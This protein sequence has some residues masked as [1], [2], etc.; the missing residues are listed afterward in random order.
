MADVTISMDVLQNFANGVSAIGT[1]ES[2]ALIE[3][4]GNID[5]S[6]RDMVED[7][8][9]GACR[10]AS[11]A[12]ADYAAQFYRGMS[13]LQTG[14]DVSGR[15]LSA[16]DRQATIIAVRGIYRQATI[17]GELDEEELARLLVERV[18]YEA[19]RSSKVGVW[20]AGQ[21]DGRDVRYARVPTGTETCAWCIM[22]AG[23]GYWFMT[24]EAASHTHA[25]CDCAIIPSIGRGDVK[26]D[27]YDSTI[28]RD[29]WRTA[30]QL[31]KNGDIPQSIADRIDLLAASRPGYR[32]DTNGT[33]AVMRYMYDLK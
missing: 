10:N 1:A 15:G 8:M 7:L 27:G 16:Y 14:K 5:L 19:N 31:R 21:R 20:R 24:E 3:T 12:S 11:Q 30:N 32:E 23:L 22:T 28:F 13:L 26:I 9:A 33:L 17:D 25:H 6:D 29:M 2:D 18:S 4:L